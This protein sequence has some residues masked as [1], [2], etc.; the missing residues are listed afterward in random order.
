M[1]LLKI[2]NFCLKHFS[3]WWIFKEIQGELIYDCYAD[4]HLSAITFAKIDLCLQEMNIKAYQICN[5]MYMVHLIGFNA[6]IHN[7]Q[8]PVGA[9]SQVITM[10]SIFY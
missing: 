3:V 6:P 10:T 5:A 9:E 1:H 4:C 8:H 7:V 2:Y